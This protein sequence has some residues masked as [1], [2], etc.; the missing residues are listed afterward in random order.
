MPSGTEGVV[1]LTGGF[2]WKRYRVRFANGAEIG[3][4]AMADIKL[5][6]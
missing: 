2:E 5:A 1:I 3:F 6:D 4:L